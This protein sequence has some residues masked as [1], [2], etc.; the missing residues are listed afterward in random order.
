MANIKFETTREVIVHTSEHIH[1]RTLDLGAGTAKYKNI[2]LE[3][4]TEYIAYDLI[5][6]KNIDVVG[7]ITKTE[8]AHNSFDTIISTQ[9]FE[10]IP[11]PWEAVKEIY[12]LLKPG[13]IAIVSAPFMN[14]YHADPYDFYRYTTEGFKALFKDGFTVLECAPYS[15]LFMVFSEMIHHTIF[16]PYEKKKTG[17]DRIMRLIQRLARFLDMF[18]TTDKIYG[19]TYIVVRK[20]K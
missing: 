8:F 12:R 1:G 18:V 19:N 5:P 3:H 16:S 6:G 13:G 2:I 10:H 14:P 9:V 11:S 15:K 20:N 7:D 4:A 17:S